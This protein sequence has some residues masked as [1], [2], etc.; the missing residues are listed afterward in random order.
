MESPMDINDQR[1]IIQIILHTV[2]SRLSTKL[3]LNHNMTAI[4]TEHGKFGEYFHRFKVTNDPTCVCRK[5]VQTVDH[6]LWEC[7]LLQVQRQILRTSTA[8]FSRSTVLPRI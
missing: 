7:D 6:V 4:M 3:V 2:Q 5:G 8:N 1:T